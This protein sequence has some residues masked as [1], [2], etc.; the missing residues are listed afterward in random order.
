MGLGP[1]LDRVLGK[2]GTGRIR[3]LSLIGKRASGAAWGRLGPSGAA[4][5]RL[6]PS[7]AVWGRLGPSGWDRLGPSGAVLGHLGPPGAAPPGAVAPSGPHWLQQ[8]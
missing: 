2:T 1:G 8:Y 4:W 7:G 3:S 5:S 6:G